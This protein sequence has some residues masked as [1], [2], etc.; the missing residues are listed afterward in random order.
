MAPQFG[1]LMQLTELQG[2]AGC[3][4]ASPTTGCRCSSHRLSA[5][6][7]GRS[8]VT[9]VTRCPSLGLRQHQYGAGRRAQRLHHR[10]CNQMGIAE[11][12]PR[13]A[14]SQTRE[15]GPV[16]IPATAADSLRTPHFWR[17]RVGLCCSDVFYETC[18]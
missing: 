2:R 11:L 4:P 15:S 13:T 14:G 8:D 17:L 12:Q 5:P 10:P 9:G 3:L 16:R 7:A 18:G 6:G 1:L